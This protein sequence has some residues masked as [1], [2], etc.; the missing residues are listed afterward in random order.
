MA[1]PTTGTGPMS[2][3]PALDKLS[4]ECMEL[5]EAIEPRLRVIQNM[6]MPQNDPQPEDP[7][8]ANGISD[9]GLRTRNALHRIAER[10]SEL[11]AM[12]GGGAF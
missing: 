5:A 3:R 11:E 6:I 10:L 12:L 7:G 9:R 2:E 4:L 1:A 8:M